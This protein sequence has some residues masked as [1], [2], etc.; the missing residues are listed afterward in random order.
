VTV[1]S[2]NTLFP[3]DDPR[4]DRNRLSIERG[5][6]RVTV[7]SR[8]L[9]SL[10]WEQRGSLVVMVAVGVAITATYFVQGLLV[11]AALGQVLVERRLDGVVWLLAGAIALTFARSALV[12]WREA[13][14][15]ALGERVASRLRTR[16]YHQ[17]VRLGPAW[18]ADTR[19]GAVQT[20]LTT[21]V[22]SLEKY[23][24]L[25]VSQAIVAAIGATAIVA[26][27]VT[28][29][30][31][32]G[33]FVGLCVLIAG[34]GPIIGWR[35]LGP[36][37]QIW[38]VQTPQLNAEYVDCLQGM[39]TL[40]VFGATKLWKKTLVANTRGLRDAS[41]SVLRAELAAVAPGRLM[42]IGGIVLTG[43][44]AAIRLVHGALDGTELLIVLIL[45]RECFRPVEDLKLAMHF[46]Y[47][48]IAGAECIL[49]VLD[50]EPVV[51]D[52]GAATPA[53]RA[54][55]LRVDGVTFSYP[56]AH[57]PALRELDF[58]LAA[59]EHV[60]LVGRSG[61]GKSTVVA[62]LMRFSDPSA[63]RILVDG[64]DIRDLDLDYYR[65]Q[66]ALV[67]QDTH[68]LHGT[69][70]DNLL[71]ARPGA[72]DAE[73]D[74]ACAAANAA[75]FIRDL[76]DGYDTVIAERGIRLSGG[77][78]QRIAIA[79][80]LLKDAPI[81]VLDEATSN[82]DVANEAAIHQALDRL[83]AGRTTLTIAHR[84]S[85]VR[86]ADRILVLDQGRLVETG[87]H[88]ELHLAGGSYQRLIEVQE[89]R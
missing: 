12:W 42:M 37:V 41:M 28:L 78:R 27:L 87:S 55:S 11:A 1:D 33:L 64:H 34:T 22:E 57:R 68:L 85:T 84:L 25:F 20:T 19:T 62:V 67:S 52:R 73:L 45:T 16:L 18:V 3:P 70:R 89:A 75:E 6:G 14:G 69:V 60:A 15:A 74:A 10:G 35:L 4:A 80:A 83:T 61:A 63:G 13:L 79:R 88:A 53:L 39:P 30:P 72:T 43:G 5:A 59:G 56:S 65:S 2:G 24:R 82:V 46:S 26:Y 77:Q 21:A 47:Q 8:R 49:D 76:P 44:L 9:L 58:E 32:I 23:F 17:L 81:L 40:K 50:A 38:W 66:I 7:W 51:S 48:G 29:D 36:R 31:V 71:L 54:P 86:N